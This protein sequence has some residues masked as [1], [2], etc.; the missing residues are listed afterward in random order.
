MTTRELD[1][2]PTASDHRY[3]IGRFSY[4]GNS[5][6]SV[7]GGHI[8]DLESLP[9]RLRDAVS[10]L[11]EEQLASP[12]REGGWTVRQ[13]VH[14]LADSHMNAYVRWKTALTEHNPTVRPYDEAVWAGM[15][16]VQQVPIEMSLALLG[17]LHARLVS[18]IRSM[19]DSDFDRTY[20]HTE[21]NR[22]LPLH[23][24]LAM[25]AWHSRHHTA[26]ITALRERS[27]W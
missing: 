3:P 23:E 10:G 22:S 18:T 11:T 15:P 19:S 9:Q 13:V 24:V 1:S 21:Q 8:A 5:S 14:H 16:D 25:Y 4:D 17:G 26:H 20:F 6:S 2:S 27:G 7:R 12:Y